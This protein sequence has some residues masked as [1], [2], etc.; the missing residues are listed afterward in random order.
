VNTT[1]QAHQAF[2]EPEVPLDTPDQ[3]QRQVLSDVTARLAAALTAPDDFPRL[4][5]AL[6]DNSRLWLRIA[7]EM[8]D[9]GSGVPQLLREQICSLAEFTRRHTS[10]VLRDKA[11]PE[12]L[13]DINT[14]LLRGL[15]GQLLPS[16]PVKPMVYQ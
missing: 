9:E 6:H 15:A 16:S 8:A 14:A 2:A 1:Q 5:Q 10:L 3:T 7:L 11:T 4:A 12:V 13:V